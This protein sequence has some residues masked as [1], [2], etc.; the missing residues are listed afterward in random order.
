[1]SASFKLN[2]EAADPL[3]VNLEKCENGMTLIYH[4]G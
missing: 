2:P 3:A 4:I 1:M